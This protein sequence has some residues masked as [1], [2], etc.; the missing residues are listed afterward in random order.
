MS[1]SQSEERTMFFT[2]EKNDTRSRIGNGIFFTCE[3]NDTSK[4]KPQ[5][6]ESF[7]SR[8]EMKDCFRM[9]LGGLY[10][11]KSIILKT[12]THAKF[13]GWGGGRANNEYCGGFEISQ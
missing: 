10:F 11:P 1:S 12:V 8:K 4:Q 7:A 13:S 6:F 5:K 2:R 3:K 9:L